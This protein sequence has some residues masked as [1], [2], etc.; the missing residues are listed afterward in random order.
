MVC[1]GVGVM[2]RNPVPVLARARVMRRAIAT[3]DYYSVWAETAP[4]IV[5]SRLKTCHSNAPGVSCSVFTWRLS[6]ASREYGTHVASARFA[7]TEKAPGRAPPMTRTRFSS[8]TRI[9]GPSVL[10]PFNVYPSLLHQ[11]AH[12]LGFRRATFLASSALAAT[13]NGDVGQPVCRKLHPVAI[14]LLL[15]LALLRQPG[16]ESSPRSLP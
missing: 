1:D 13:V 6:A 11:K 3:W 2:K 15:L 10:D 4:R 9:W 14:T 8:A 5:L 16:G 7:V 12:R